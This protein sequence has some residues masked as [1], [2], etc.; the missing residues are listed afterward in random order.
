MTLRHHLERIGLLACALLAVVMLGF[1]GLYALRDLP[2]L[3]PAYQQFRALGWWLDYY[4]GTNVF[5][6]PFIW[7]SF[8]TGI[9]TGITAPLVGT[10]VVHREMALV[11]ETLAHAAF[12]G[13]ALGLVLSG[14]TGWTGSLLLVALVV[15]IVGAL[16]VQWLAERTSTYGDVPIAIV[17]S[18]SFAVGT[19]LVS[20]GR[21]IATVPID[22][23]GIL[24]GNIGIVTPTGTRLMAAI[25][26]FVVIA[27]AVTYKQL[28]FIT[29]D[30]Q[31]ARVA[32]L[33]VDRYNTAL[34]VM[35]AIVVVGALQILGVILV[36]AMLVIP[37]AAASQVATSFT[38]TQYLA[39]LFGELAVILGFAISI[40]SELPTGGT[41]VVVAI[42]I[43]L[44]AVT[45]S[46][47]ATAPLSAR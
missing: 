14:L 34:I 35:T 38:E 39:V 16:G 21:T 37:V 28:L 8:A 32:Q 13:V 36:A 20:W 45:S 41:I 27:I 4:L 18:G 1:V 29:F 23:E 42:A 15:G 11:G 19:L 44:L 40:A 2:L 26:L 43:Y 6:H 31:A 22:I 47:H 9:F 30:E 7:Q 10:Y 46:T 25:T 24:F 33:S 5:Y 12:A 17:L 3:E